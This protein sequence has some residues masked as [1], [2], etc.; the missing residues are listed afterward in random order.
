[1]V[2]HFGTLEDPRDR[3]SEILGMS[4][5]QGLGNGLNTFFANRSLQSVLQDKSS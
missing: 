1:M 3:I 2:Q 4:L 5:G